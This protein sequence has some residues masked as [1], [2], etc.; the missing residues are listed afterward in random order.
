MRLPHQESSRQSYDG[1]AFLSFGFRPFFL[2]GSIFSACA[3]GAW[4]AAY[5]FGAPEIGGRP[6]IDWH[7]HEMLF[8]FFAAIAAG[9]LL[10]AIPNWTARLPVMGMGLALLFG[11]WL[12]GRV[13]MLLPLPWPWVAAAVDCSFLI[14]F[15]ALVWREILAGR[16]RRN[17][18]V[19]LLV[20]ILAA[21]NVAYHLVDG[22]L[23]A[24]QVVQRVV[25]TVPALLISLIGGRIIPSF[26]R[27][28]LVQRGEA[29]R[30]APADR[31]D[32]FALALAAT[33]FASWIVLPISLVTGG[34]LLFAGL[35]HGARLLRWRGWRAGSEALVWI[36]HAGYGWLALAMVLLGLSIL[37]PQAVPASAAIHALTTGAMGVMILAVMTRATLGHTG[38]PRA[39]DGW[40]TLIFVFVIAAALLRVLSGFMPFAL[41]WPMLATAG[42]LWTGAFA[43]FAIRYGPLLV[44]PRGNAQLGQTER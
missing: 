3:I 13:V 30:P 12:S 42:V 20:T 41:D 40:T 29:A 37:V 16:N 34:L 5:A 28:W 6:A 10:T 32:L 39:A 22:D 18:A 19:C 2:G 38:R 15:A 11:L 21:A 1:P 36:L 23:V 14:V 44:F 4:L 24:L 33:A 27:N 25:L 43:I 35:V 26:T 9:F 7:I 8:G 17:V 31:F